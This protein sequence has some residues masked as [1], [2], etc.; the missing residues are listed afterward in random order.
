MRII[1]FLLF[2]SSVFAK[3]PEVVIFDFGGVM[4]KVDRKPMILFLSESLGIPYEKVKEDFA[5]EKI[6][7]SFEKS[8]D[9]WEKYAQKTMLPDEWYEE[10]RHMQKVIV[11]MFPGMKNIVVELKKQGFKVALLSN[12]NRYRANFIQK[13]GAYAHFQPVILS[14]DLGVS[15]PHPNIYKRVFKLLNTEPNKCLFIDNKK[16][17]IEA[18]QKFGMDGIVFESPL[19]LTEELNKRGIKIEFPNLSLIETLL[20]E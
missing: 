8:R 4:G 5:K 7:Q 3:L 20:V 1:L 19:Q 12:T 15:K 14:C 6:Y 17:N 11:R 18:G 2:C 16:L 9:F 13:M 10:F